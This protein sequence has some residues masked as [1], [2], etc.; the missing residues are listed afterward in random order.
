MSKCREAF[1]ELY[2]KQELV[3]S[4]TNPEFYADFEVTRAWR[5]WQAAWNAATQNAVEVCRELK[6][7][8]DTRRNG[9]DCAV[10]IE[11]EIEK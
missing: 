2:G 8:F 4:I 10:R 11:K 3:R 6:M 7:G 9:Y 5:Y 1:E